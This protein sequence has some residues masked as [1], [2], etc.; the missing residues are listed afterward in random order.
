[1]DF[2]LHIAKKTGEGKA[3]ARSPQCGMYQTRTGKMPYVVMTVEFAKAVRK[4]EW[5]MCQR[6][7]NA[8]VEQGRISQE[9]A[10]AAK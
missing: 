1:M 10:K 9:T 2:V 4:G 7:M 6:C 5:K 3:D 8:A